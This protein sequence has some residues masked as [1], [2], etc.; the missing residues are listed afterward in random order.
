[1]KAESAEDILRQPEPTQTR[2]ELMEE[3]KQKIIEKYGKIRR[4]IYTDAELEPY[5]KPFRKPPNK[6]EIIKKYGI[7]KKNKT[8]S[9]EYLLAWHRKH[10][11]ENKE[12]MKAKSIKHHQENK[13]YRSAKQKQY[14]E[15]NRELWKAYAKKYYQENKELL[16]IKG[17]KWYVENRTRV[18]ARNRRRHRLKR[19]K[20]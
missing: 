15:K 18:L 16:I 20:K 2:K 3:K 14:R 19:S 12:Y 10:Y 6:K 4:K 17:R 7:S 13:K 11:E 9:S 1:M 8:K 5:S